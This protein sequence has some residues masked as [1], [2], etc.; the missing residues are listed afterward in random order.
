VNVLVCCG[1]EWW[2]LVLAAL[3]TARQPVNVLDCLKLCSAEEPHYVSIHFKHPIVMIYKLH[4]SNLSTTPKCV[5]FSE[6]SIHY[7]M[8][9]PTWPSSGHTQYIQNTWEVV[10]N[11]KFYKKK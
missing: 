4:S 9:R 3:N 2:Y 7:Y 1:Y 6:F 11:I 10:S 8:F 5:L